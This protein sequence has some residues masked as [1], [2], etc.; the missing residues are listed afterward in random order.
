VE[1]EGITVKPIDQEYM[2]VAEVAEY[3]GTSRQNIVN[4]RKKD[5]LPEPEAELAMGPVW[6][7]KT[8]VDYKR[9]R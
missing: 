7:T 6:L 2:G 5:K 8:I 1:A 3:L 4:M 9:N